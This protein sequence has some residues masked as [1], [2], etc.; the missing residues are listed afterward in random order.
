MGNDPDLLLLPPIFPIT[1]R[2]SPFELENGLKECLLRDAGRPLIVYEEDRDW[3]RNPAA[4]GG[5][6][7]HPLKHRALAAIFAGE[8]K[9]AAHKGA[10]GEPHHLHRLG[11]IVFLL[12]EEVEGLEDSEFLVLVADRQ[13]NDDAQTFL[14]HHRGFR[15]GVWIDHRPLSWLRK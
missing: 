14:E 13:V 5:V 7:P 12:F 15:W 10:V 6:P 11:R 2:N 8:R 3:V 9:G 4:Q 1:G